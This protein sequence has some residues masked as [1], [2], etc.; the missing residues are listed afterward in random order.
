MICVGRNYR[1]HATELNNAIP[2][3]PVL[4]LKP[5]TA[6]M[7]KESDFYIPEFSNEIHY[8]LEVV[9]RIDKAGKYI[10]EEFAHRHFSEISLGIDF[11][12][13]DLQDQ[14]KSQSLPWE[15]AKAFDNSAYVG[16]FFPKS[17]L[18]LQNI[19]FELLKNNETVQLGNTADML[20]NFD[21]IIAY[22]SQFFSLKIGDFIFTGTPKGVGKVCENDI[23]IGKLNDNAIFKLN[24]K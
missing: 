13:R 6:L 23:L 18:D 24:I 11:T 1:E 20:F 17:E 16:P 14:Q 10:P 12:A 3:Q 22:A 2:T 4:F 15:I 5:D 9:L 21:K 19:N 7:N 8:E